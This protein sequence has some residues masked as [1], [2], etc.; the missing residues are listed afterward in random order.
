MI[1]AGR[2]NK[3]ATFYKVDQA[4]DD[5]GEPTEAKTVRC[6]EWVEVMDQRGIERTFG[7]QQGA[8]IEGA[9]RMRFNENS[10]LVTH[11]DRM[12]IEGD[13]HELVGAPANV[14]AAN[15]E[16]VFTFKRDMREEDSTT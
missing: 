7:E 2:L 11:A 15:A 5:A 3:L 8:G 6:T 14:G 4:F 12:T 16:L 10:K 9:A 13:D 1:D